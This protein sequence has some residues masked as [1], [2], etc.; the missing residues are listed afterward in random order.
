MGIVFQTTLTDQEKLRIDDACGATRHDIIGKS[1]NLFNAL[2]RHM[3]TLFA[4]LAAL[5]NVS[6]AAQRKLTIPFVKA[7]LQI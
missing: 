3:S 2:S 4:A 7:V 5:N 6:L 1:A